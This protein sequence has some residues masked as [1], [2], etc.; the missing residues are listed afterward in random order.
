[1]YSSIR[2]KTFKYRDVMASQEETLYGADITNRPE[3]TTVPAGFK[4]IVVADPLVVYMSDGT[5]WIEV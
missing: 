2:E 1:M 5:N 4:F 3:A